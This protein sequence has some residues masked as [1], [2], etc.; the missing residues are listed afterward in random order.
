VL[1]I[2]LVLVSAEL[3]LERTNDLPAYVAASSA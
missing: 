1:W 3:V 2:L